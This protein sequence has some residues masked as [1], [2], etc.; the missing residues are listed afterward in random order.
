MTNDQIDDLKQ[1]IATTVRH[2][3]SHQIS[4]QTEELRAELVE[5][6]EAIQ[7]VEHKVDDLELVVNTIADA[8]GAQFDNHEQR[9]TKLETA[10]LTA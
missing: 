6:K 7:R 10:Q 8:T 3:V 2:E 5:V 1:F 4:G 9:I